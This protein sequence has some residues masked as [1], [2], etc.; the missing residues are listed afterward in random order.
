MSIYVKDPE[1]T[2]QACVIWM[3][4]LGADAQDMAGLAAELPLTVPVR[5]VFLDAP[6]RPV[7]LNN[8]ML[9]RAWYDISGMS[10][11]DRED[12]AGIKE[13]E[14]MICEVIGAQIEA[15]FSAKQIFLAGFSQGGAMA[16]YTGMH[17]SMPLGGLIVLSAYLPLLSTC[18]IAQDK[19][20]AI[21]AAGGL[22]DPIV[23][24]IWTHMSIDYLRQQGFEQIAQHDYPMEHS[25][26]NEEIVDLANWLNQQ[27]SAVT[28]R[29][30]VEYDNC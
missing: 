6:V 18:Q 28:R 23:L 15:G 26:C 3:H 17:S 14:Q 7:T 19:Q 25:I 21:F 29:D 8:N 22:Y 10:L 30:G 20:T 2:A 5:H 1:Q 4:G 12:S 9:M 16:L 11:T 24:P 27:V 13:S